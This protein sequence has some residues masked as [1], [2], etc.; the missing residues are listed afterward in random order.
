MPSCLIYRSGK[1]EETYLYLQLGKRFEDLPEGLRETF[2]E[3]SLVMKL[4]IG[5]DTRLAQADAENVLRALEEE[6]Y[7]LQLP[8]KDPIEELISRRFA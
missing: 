3:P 2:G 7:F 5:P 8:P 1:K 4:D 6:G